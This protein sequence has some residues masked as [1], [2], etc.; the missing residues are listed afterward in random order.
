M[1]AC[2]HPTQCTSHQAAALLRNLLR[3]LTHVYSWRSMHFALHWQAQLC[4]A[5][6]VVSVPEAVLQLTV[7]LPCPCSRS[8][9]ATVSY[10]AS[11]Q[12][13]PTR[14][15]NGHR[16]TQS[17]LPAYPQ[18]PPG[19]AHLC[20]PSS[21]QDQSLHQ[22]VRART[23]QGPS[24]ADALWPE[25]LRHQPNTPALA[26]GH[27]Q[28][29][30]HQLGKQQS[31]NPFASDYPAQ[32]RD[33]GQA[34]LALDSLRHAASGNSF[35][36]ATETIRE[37]RSANTE[38]QAFAELCIG[39]LPVTSNV[40]EGRWSDGDVQAGIA[41]G[42]RMQIQNQQVLPG[43][44]SA[45]A[46]PVAS[47]RILKNPEMS[48]LQNGLIRCDQAQASLYGWAS[49]FKHCP[50]CLPSLIWQQPYTLHYPTSPMLKMVTAYLLA[51]AL[52]HHTQRRRFL[53]GC[54]VPI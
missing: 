1:I 30:S 11:P 7:A 50:F 12:Q 47:P 34:A 43:S 44:V 38:H 8:S 48:P 18:R 27:Q 36:A 24:R 52:L 10:Q 9:S 25:P 39:I 35:M 3:N 22:L 16:L 49:V 4:M 28:L 53:Q 37:S 54:S 13:S 46:S 17:M 15:A 20:S 51:A 33:S 40:S 31:G 14:G 5:V 32:G 21:P 19:L 42:G 6:L 45:N 2:S 26:T 41:A 23:L 29:P